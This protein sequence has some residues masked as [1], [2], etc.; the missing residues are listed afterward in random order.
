MHFVYPEVP[1]MKDM[2]STP[3][4]ISDEFRS[5]IGNVL[6]RASCIHVSE[7]DTDP[8]FSLLQA[9]WTTFFN[10]LFSAA[11]KIHFS[12]APWGLGVLVSVKKRVLRV[13]ALY[14]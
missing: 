7:V 13:P 1:S 14:A 9:Y 4:L 12:T 3:T 6:V 11:M 5:L 10:P 8:Y 2:A